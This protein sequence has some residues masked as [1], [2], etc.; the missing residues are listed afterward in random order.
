MKK[1]DTTN[2][3]LIIDDFFD[4]YS[5]E[6]LRDTAGVAECVRLIAKEIEPEVPIEIIS[7]LVEA[8]MPVEP[9]V[10]SAKG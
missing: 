5:L 9:K 6:E 3:R 2:I 4:N 10:Y 1:T 8:K 7:K